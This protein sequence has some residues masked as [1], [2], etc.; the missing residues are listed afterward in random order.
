MINETLKQKIDALSV[1]ELL[2]VQRFAPVG[3]PRF[4]GEEGQ[5]RMARLAELRSQDNA[6]YVSA[7]KSIGW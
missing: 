2:S 1:Q 6:A 3:D 4:Q 5:Y 7:S